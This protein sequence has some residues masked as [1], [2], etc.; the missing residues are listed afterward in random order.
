[1]K[2]LWF[3]N[4]PAN[5]TEYLKLPTHGGGWLKT[6]DLEI[7]KKVDLH[8]AFFENHPEE[9]FKYKNTTYYVLKG[10][11]NK[12]KI[13]KYLLF[14]NK[15]YERYLDSYLEVI[16]KVK[17]DLIHIHGTEDFFLPIINHTTIPVIVSIQGILNGIYR[18]YT[19]YFTLKDLK[20]KN[21]N[22]NAP[23]KKILFMRSFFDNFKELEFKKNNEEKYLR[24]LKYVIGRT[25]WD[26]YY[27]KA[28]SP[29][30]IYY[31]VD[32]I[33]R[34]PFYELV[35]N[36]LE[37]GKLIIQ[38]TI[39]D[40]PYKGLETIFESAIVLNNLGI[41]YEWRIAGLTDID[42]TV[43]LLLKKLGSIPPNIK[44]LG[45]LIDIDLKEKIDNCSIFVLTSHIDNS[46]NSL[47]EAMLR[48][49]PC[50][51]TFAG[52]TN[53]ILENNIE[54]IL[55]Q[56]GDPYTLAGAIISLNNDPKLQKFLGE[57]ARKKAIIRNDKN[58][59]IEQLISSYEDILKK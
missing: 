23:W 15:D 46:S 47:C 40:S 10:K 8:V 19:S 58:K 31:K 22:W 59:I 12:F 4:T 37:S 13:I 51:A 24:N 9:E 18:K 36:Y 25:D 29:N 20:Y 39:S 6:I 57:N 52:G 11:S 27:M 17:P 38:S 50:I 43:K 32:E 35:D 42:V 49:K 26:N 30:A 56:P 5:A 21:I 2:V 1:M 54:G 53:T 33:M 45:K 16:N 28:L 14:K 48:G 44:L 3:S 55:L 7:Q 34:E 41:K